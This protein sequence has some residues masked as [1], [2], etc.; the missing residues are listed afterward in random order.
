MAVKMETLEPILRKH[1]FFK[2]LPEK[3]FE[4]ILSCASHKLFKADEIILK[5]GESADKFY[6]I[7]SGHVAIYIDHPRQITIQTIG[8]GEILGWSWLA[9]PYR[10]RFSAQAVENTRAVA[11]DGKCLREKCEKNSELGYELLKRLVS[12]FTKRLEETRL[13]LLD[14]YNINVENK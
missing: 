3:H 13:R 9:P 5:Q 7:R 14:I 8:E 11:L 12:V 6:L 1:S 10:Y 2:D 4:F